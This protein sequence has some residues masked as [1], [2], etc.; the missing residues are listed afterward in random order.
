MSHLKDT[1]TYI[2]FMNKQLYLIGGVYE[3]NN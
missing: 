2:T 1:K 3:Y